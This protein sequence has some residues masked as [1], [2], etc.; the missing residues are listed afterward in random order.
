[1]MKGNRVTD[2]LI[3]IGYLAGLLLVILPLLLVGRY[4][5]PS[6]D[7]W[8]FGYRTYE[9]VLQGGGIFAV[10]KASFQTVA[11]NYLN[12]EGR[13]S[14]A[15]FATL[16]P[17]IWGEQYYKIVVWM[18]LGILIGTEF[19]VA[20]VM[21][22]GASEKTKR[23]WLPLIAPSVILQ[24]LYSPSVVE[25]F[26][27]YVGAV[28][29][30]AI[31]MLSLLFLV[32]FWKLWEGRTGKGYGVRLFFL[33]VLSVIIGG[34][35]F[36]TSLS[37]ILAMLCAYLL[38]YLCYGRQKGNRAVKRTFI[39]PVFMIL[40]LGACILSPAVTQRLRANFGGTT[41]GGPVTAIAESL[42]RSFWNMV[43][44]TDLKILLMIL[45]VLP[46]VYACAREAGYSFRWPFVFTVLSF[47]V[48]ASQITATL[49][50]DGT[51]G[52]GRMAA[53]LYYTYHL[54]ILANLFYWVGWGIRKKGKL[55]AA[56][57]NAGT[58]I[59]AYLQK[60]LLVYCACLGILLVGVI[61]RFDLK[62]I[63]SYR[64]YRDLRQGWAQT[65][66]EEWQER[67]KVLHDPDIREVEF[68]PLSVY[69]ETILYT[70]LQEDDGYIWV[71]RDCATYYQKTSIRV[72]GE[73]AVE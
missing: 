55:P 50:V 66:Y 9:T 25:S 43:S 6:A 33:I 21:F 71:N 10:L 60:Y 45:L 27:W 19:L 46:F 57:Q 69:P 12:W 28:N 64:A 53:I 4:N 5:L 22:G 68:A 40:S 37:T 47:G 23:A 11:D 42:V 58:K 18:M 70:D 62:S 65:Y 13:F 56:V 41:T 54:W 35:N 59:K 20:K 51:T 17:G 24:I 29:Y 39:L 26:F 15:F 32:A 67:Y 8:S 2:Y 31:C 7:D 36:A 44:W 38:Q 34:D 61:Y 48:Y 72:I 16:Q 63:S 14:N 1:M 3:S 49:Y 52:G 73:E 30:T